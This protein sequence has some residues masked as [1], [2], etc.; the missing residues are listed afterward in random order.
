MLN[1]VFKIFTSIAYLP[2]RYIKFC[3]L[4]KVKMRA[5]SGL[6]DYQEDLVQLYLKNNDYINAYGWSYLLVNKGL[7]NYSDV[8][9]LCKSKLGD[10]DLEKAIYNA[11]CI[12]RNQRLII[13]KEYTL[14]EVKVKIAEFES[15]ENQREDLLN[16][17]LLINRLPTEKSKIMFDSMQ[18]VKIITK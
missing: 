13:K 8:M 14:E 17:C 10:L 6:Q 12:A 7:K 11:D 9:E 15:D 1:K 4:C 18:Q 5:Q 16:L 3:I 2:V